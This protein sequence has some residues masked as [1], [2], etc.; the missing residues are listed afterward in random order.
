MRSNKF[1]FLDFDGVLHS[2]SPSIDDFFGK[3]PLLSD[4]LAVHPC[5]VVISSSWRFNSELDH[6]KAKL[7]DPLAKLVV[8]KTGKP[9]IGQWPRY[10]EIKQ[11]LRMNKPLAEGR[12]LDDAFLEFPKDCPELIPCHPKYG[13]TNQEIAKLTQWLVD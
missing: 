1:L 11:Y 3:A 5:H 6:L 7:P 4:L 10:S 2:T 12:A 9:E 8:G 13:I